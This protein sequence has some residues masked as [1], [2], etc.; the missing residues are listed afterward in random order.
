MI[1]IIK[2]LSKF[3]TVYLDLFSLKR[4]LLRVK[5]SDVFNA[6]ISYTLMRDSCL[7]IYQV[8]TDILGTADGLIFPI[9]EFR[10]KNKLFEKGK[11][12]IN[13]KIMRKS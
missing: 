3:Q 9:K 8:N 4:F 6:V 12:G 1:V 10:N 11:R 5:D 7:I 13:Q 2:E